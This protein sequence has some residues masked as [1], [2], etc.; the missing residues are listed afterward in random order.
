[1]VITAAIMKA[2][3]ITRKNTESQTC[4]RC[5]HVQEALKAVKGVKSAKVSLEAKSAQV[6]Y[7]PAKTGKEELVKAVEA[8][9]YT[10]R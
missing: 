6:T 5:R 4:C 9:G 7:V 10:A 1:M 3:P 2:K 8:A